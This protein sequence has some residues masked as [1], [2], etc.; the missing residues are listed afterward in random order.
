LRKL[1]ITGASG[2]LGQALIPK[3]QDNFKL[4][5]IGRTPVLQ[6][7][8]ISGKVSD[9]IFLKKT[10]KEFSP[11]IILHFSAMTNVDQCEMNPEESHLINSLSVKWML[12]TFA[13]YFLFISTDYV[14]NGRNGPYLESDN[15]NP[16]NVYGQTKLKAENM[17]N[18]NSENSLILRTN[19]LFDYN[20]SSKASF[21]NWVVNSLQN[22]TPISVVSDQYNNPIWTHH[23]AEIIFFLI[24]EKITGLLHTGSDEYINRYEFALIIAQKFKLDKSLIKPI[25]THDLKQIASRPLRGGLKIDKL[26]YNYNIP[27]PS[28]EGALDL[29]SS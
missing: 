12:E 13:G 2:Q 17:I 16:I 15:T 3:I 11:D 7:P 26:K 19:V 8:W 9:P 28:L 27:V 14:F 20:D 24:K 29:I 25:Q 21:V 18:L 1:L 4:L 6:I 22:S 5:C 23:L 10:I